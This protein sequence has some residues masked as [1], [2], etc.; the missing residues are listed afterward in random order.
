LIEDIHSKPV[1]VLQVTQN[2]VAYQQGLWVMNVIQVAGIAFIISFGLGILFLLERNIVK[3][4]TKLADYVREMP[5]SPN[6]DP[7]ISVSSE[8]VAVLANAVRDA[9]KTKLEGM[10]EVSR[11][12]GHDLRNPLTGIKGA[13]YILKKNYGS[14]MDEKGNA[15][16][17]TID[18]CVAYSDKIVRDLLEYSCEIK[19]DKIKT[20]PKRLV[21]DSLSTLVVPSNI[22]VINEASDELSTL[23]D[24]GKIE[25][26]FTN[27]I[28]NAFDA[29]PNGGK[30]H[31]TSRKMNNMVEVDFS[32]KGVGMSKAV[33]EKL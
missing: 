10:N 9:I 26:I 3:P 24:N 4:M 30:L 29:M 28:K 23:V 22:E 17:K 11:M 6:A 31:I 16:L 25:R 19:L 18:D 12:V 27:L 5:F 7:K 15:M 20:S 33:L 8:E 32:D 13:S 21:N 1:F 14:K 2:R